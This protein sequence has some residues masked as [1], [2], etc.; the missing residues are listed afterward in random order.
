MLLLKK[1][2][3]QIRIDMII[4]IIIQIIQTHGKI[5]QDVHKAWTPGKKIKAYNTVFI[6]IVSSAF[7]LSL[8]MRV[9]TSFA[10]LAKG[11][12]VFGKNN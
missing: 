6:Q 5:I 12:S 8:A 10:K 4:D 3:K 9:F 1:K 11:G 2:N 7:F